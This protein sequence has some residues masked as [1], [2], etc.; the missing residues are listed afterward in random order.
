VLETEA[1]L[2]VLAELG[3]VVRGTDPAGVHR[4]REPAA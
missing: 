4:Y 3:Q 2:D 1:H